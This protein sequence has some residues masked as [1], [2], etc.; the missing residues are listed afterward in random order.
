MD[1]GIG[2]FSKLVGLSIDT[3]RYY[4]K[5]HLILPQRDDNNRRVYT[6]H[7]VKW[8]AFIKRLKQ[9]G[10]PIKDI[11]CYATLRYQ[12]DAT[13]AERLSL[14]YEQRQRLKADQVELQRHVDFLD[15]K[16]TTYHQMQHQL[17]AKPATTPATQSDSN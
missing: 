2:Q 11:Q 15:A 4:E 16:I 1:Y 7:D 17:L 9:T 14:L 8:I 10:M 5:E 3:L 13:I 6:D 12:G